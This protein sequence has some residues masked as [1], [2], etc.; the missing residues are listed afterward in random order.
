MRCPDECLTGCGSLAG[1]NSARVE[2]YASPAPRARQVQA[3]V[4]GRAARHDFP[5]HREA[6]AR[7][8]MAPAEEVGRRGQRVAARAHPRETSNLSA[9]S[10][11]ALGVQGRA[12]PQAPAAPPRRSAMPG[13]GGRSNPNI[14]LARPPNRSRLSCGRLTRRRKSSRRQSVPRQGHNTPVPLERSAPASFKRLLGRTS[15]K[16]YTWKARI[17][18]AFVE[19]IGR[20]ANLLGDCGRS[21]R[22]RHESE[23]IKEFLE[24]PGN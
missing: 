5:H 11:P 15:S 22:N 17:L 6:S 14:S 4:R 19:L 20:E 16:P 23:G 2:F 8:P 10:A 1:A 12:A 18:L 13:R 9:T 21:P 3:P 7:R 24:F